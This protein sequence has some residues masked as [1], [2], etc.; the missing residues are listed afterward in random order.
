MVRRGD[1]LDTEDVLEILAIELIGIIP[2][3]EAV[4]VSTNK[5]V[6]VALDHNSPSGLA[7]RRIARRLL[8]EEVPFLP[9]RTQ[10][11]L[12]DRVMHLIRQR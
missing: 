12:L 11:G 10:P 4:I 8:G 6:P 3:D 1:M 9:L 7:F 5:G 2:E